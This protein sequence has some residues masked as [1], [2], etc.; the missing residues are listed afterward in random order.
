LETKLGSEL[1]SLELKI[2]ELQTALSEIGDIDSAQINA[3]ALIVKYN[4]V[5]QDL[6]TKESTLHNELA[7]VSLVYDKKRSNLAEN[8]TFNNLSS[9]EAKFKEI[10]EENRELKDCN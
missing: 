8:E 7:E 9:L 10:D 2:V 3:K 6:K 5:L 4:A 1:E